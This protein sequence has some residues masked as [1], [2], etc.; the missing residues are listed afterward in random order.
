MMGFIRRLAK[1]TPAGMIA[2]AVFGKNK[3][4]KEPEGTL[5]TSSR[6]T[7]TTGVSTPSIINQKQIY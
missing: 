7:D 3:K 5:A 6:A 4:K 2:S 1:L